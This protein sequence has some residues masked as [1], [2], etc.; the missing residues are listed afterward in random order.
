MENMDC[1]VETIHM[2][3]RNLKYLHYCW[4]YIWGFGVDPYLIE[5]LDVSWVPVGVPPTMEGEQWD[6]TIG[7]WEEGNKMSLHMVEGID[8]HHKWVMGGHKG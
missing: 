1:F 6:M 5:R 3:Y 4:G 7:E 2:A 8:L